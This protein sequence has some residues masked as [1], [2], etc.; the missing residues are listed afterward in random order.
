MPQKTKNTLNLPKR[1]L[2][3]QLAFPVGKV[4]MP[5]RASLAGKRGFVEYYRSF[6]SK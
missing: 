2:L 3:G 6:S 1:T 4:N 5:L